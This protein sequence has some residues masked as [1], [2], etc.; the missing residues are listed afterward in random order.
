M[1]VGEAFLVI[2]VLF[3]AF[4]LPAFD[5]FFF[6]SAVV[7]S[8]FWLHVIVLARMCFLLTKTIFCQAIL[9]KRFLIRLQLDFISP[10]RRHQSSAHSAFSVGP[11]TC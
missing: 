7:A 6:C 11:K 10:H 4:Y 3:G 2:H 5:V 8:F 1:S 9:Y